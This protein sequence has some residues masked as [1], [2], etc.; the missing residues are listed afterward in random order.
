[1]EL[2]QK[3][4]KSLI[5]VIIPTYK[6]SEYLW[7]CLDSIASQEL[8]KDA[9]E[10]IVVLNG[11]NEPYYSDI[12]QYIE[13]S[14]AGL[15]IHLLQT[16][17][18]GVSNAR[19][20]ALD[21]ARGE[22]IAFIDDDDWVSPSYLKALLAGACPDAVTVSDVQSIDD[23]TG[24][25]R[26]DYLS[27]TYRQL[28]GKGDMTVLTARRFLSSSCCK[29]IPQ[30]VIGKRRF[31]TRYAVGEDALFMASLTNRVRFIR[32]ASSE[33]VYY[34]RWRAESASRKRR[35]FGKKV[36]NC[37]RLYV[38]YM[39]IYLSNPLLYNF[40]FFLNRLAAVSKNLFQ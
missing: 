2:S 14:T 29:L 12:R 37:C 24:E 6:P 21:N 20:M 30:G 40:F 22:Y 34:R 17:C 11:C 28:C 5:S 25:S 10:V 23:Q 4:R 1:M 13:S 33:A 16:D 9:F 39:Q 15:D 26:P 8:P 18:P 19:N 38:S 27:T 36:L 3:H 31:D 7:Q 35:S 32:C